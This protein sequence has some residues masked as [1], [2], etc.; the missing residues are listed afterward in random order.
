MSKGFS[1]DDFK[2]TKNSPEL[3]SSEEK[4]P[5]WVDPEKPKIISLYNGVLIEFKRVKKLIESGINISPKQRKIVNLEV[6]KHADVVKSYLRADRQDTKRI[7]EFIVEKNELLQELWS[8]KNSLKRSSGSKLLRSE[9]EIQNKLL[10]Q[11]NAKLLEWNA[12]EYFQQW[13]DSFLINDSKRM[14][15]KIED[16]QSQ[17]DQLNEE[18]IKLKAEIQKLR[19]ERN[20]LRIIQ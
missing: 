3:D 16:L 1:L 9:L 17:V 2:K 8:K 15:A 19:R 5:Y 4:L 7:L 10:K 13:V 20:N 11:E 12:K 14:V 18:N 6:C